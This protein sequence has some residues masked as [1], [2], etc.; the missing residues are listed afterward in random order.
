M[1]LFNVLFVLFFSLQINSQTSLA[2]LKNH[3]RDKAAFSKALKK[4]EDSKQ[5]FFYKTSPNFGY[6]FT[7]TYRDL[8]GDNKSYIEVSFSGN[9]D[10][11]IASVYT[12]QK[13]TKKFVLSSTIHGKERNNRMK[14]VRKK[15]D[16]YVALEDINIPLNYTN[17]ELSL[18]NFS[19]ILYNEDKGIYFHQFYYK[20]KYKCQKANG[21]LEYSYS[22]HEWRQSSTPGMCVEYVNGRALYKKTKEDEPSEEEESILNENIEKIIKEA[23]N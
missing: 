8:D 15:G 5:I 19:Y 7:G 9:K 10:T 2:N 14:Y 18:I 3:I 17:K 11:L 20:K 4:I 23:Y 6:I 13:S 1:K 16:V 21:N 22:L 12:Y